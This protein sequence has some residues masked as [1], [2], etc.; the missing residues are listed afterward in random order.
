M[1]LRQKGDDSEPTSDGLERAVGLHKV[2]DETAVTR[3]E[4]AEGKRKVPS[5]SAERSRSVQAKVGG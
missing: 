3:K 1:L 2:Y 5:A 4:E